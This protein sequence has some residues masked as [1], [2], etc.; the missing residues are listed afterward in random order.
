MRAL[1]G[2]L[3]RL[4]LHLFPR[5]LP[6]ALVLGTV[7]SLPSLGVGFFGD[8]YL[9][10]AILDGLPAPGTP[11]SLFTFASGDPAEMRRFLELGPYPWWTLPEVKLSFWRPLSSAL[12]VLDHTLFGRSP[13]PYHVHS[14]LWHLLTILV[15]AGVLRRLPGAAGGLALLFFVVD[16]THVFPVMWVANRNALVATA[17]ALFGLWMH[18]RWREQGWRPGLPLSLLGLAVGLLGGET[19][20]GAFVYLGAYELLGN[21]GPKAARARALVPAFLLGLA[22]FLMYRALGHGAYGSGTYFDPVADWQQYL[23]GLAT[24]IP[25]LLAGLLWTLPPELWVLLPSLRPVQVLVGCFAIAMGVF[26]TAA[27]RRTLS[28]DEWRH[29]RWLMAGGLLSLLPVAATFPAAR[30]L[31]MPSLGASA[32]LSVI[33]LGVWRSLPGLR[34]W[35]RWTLSGLTAAMFSVQGL[36]TI[37]WG[38]YPYGLRAVGDASLEAIARIEVDDARISRQRVVSLVVPDPLIGLYPAIIRATQGRPPARSWLPLSLAPYDHVLHRTSDAAFE[39][40]LAEGHFLTTELEQLFRGPGFAMRVGDQVSVKGCRVTLLETD[41]SLPQRIRFEFDMSLDDPDLVLLT[42]QEGTLRRLQPP[43]V[44]ETVRL[45][46]VQL[47]VG[48]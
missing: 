1:L 44:G 6:V 14:I 5:A 35:R 9:H 23:P 37:F 4:Q 7:L 28:A 41:G 29:T 20:L 48:R 21:P 17:P 11:F 27:V 47:V 13:V 16:E 3:K 30:L 38:L 32:L 45:T 25:A 19:A 40:S 42:Q 31:L 2:R 24:R 12:M 34:G 36:A 33:A 22:Y 39:L 43:P 46:W 18:L 10:L 26:L 8:D 15:A